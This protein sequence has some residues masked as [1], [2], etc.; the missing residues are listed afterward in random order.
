[1]QGGGSRRAMLAVDAKTMGGTIARNNSLDAAALAG[2][3]GAHIQTIQVIAADGRPVD[4][5][6]GHNHNLHPRPKHLSPEEE[7]RAGM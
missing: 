3:G 5:P 2:A 4:M 1:M 7:R 6:A